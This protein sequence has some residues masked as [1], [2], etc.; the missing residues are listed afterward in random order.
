MNKLAIA[1]VAAAVTAMPVA[2]N[3]EV[4]HSVRRGV[5]QVVNPGFAGTDGWNL[6]QDTFYDAATSRTPD[7]SGS[8]VLTTPHGQPDYSFLET[9]LSSLISVEPGKTYTLSAYV[10]TAGWPNFISPF[11][12]RYG[13]SMPLTAIENTDEVRFGTSQDGVWE[14]IVV[15]YTAEPGDGFAQAKFVKRANTQDFGKVWIDD[16]YFG[17]GIGLERPPSTKTPF[18]GGSVRVDGEGNFEVRRDDGWQPFFPLCVYSDNRRPKSVYSDQGFNCDIRL[19]DVGQ[20][21]AAAAAVSDFNPD[22]LMGGFDFS[23]YLDSNMDVFRDVG[24]LT[25]RLTE[26]MASDAVDNLLLFHWDNENDF[27]R[28]QLIGE[29][30]DRVKAIDMATDGARQRPVYA[31]NGNYGLARSQAAS[32]FVEV[33][34]TY[35]WSSGAEDLSRA[36]GSIG[37]DGLALIQKFEGQTIPV[38]FAQLNEVNGAGAMRRRLYQ[39]IIEGAKGMGFWRDCFNSQCRSEFPPDE[40]RPIDKQEW[41]PDFPGLR[42][43]IDAMLPLIRQPLA[44]D[45]AVDSSDPEV[46]HRV[47]EFE[48]E[49]YLI[50][51]NLSSEQ[52][53]ATFDIAEA[54]YRPAEVVDFFSGTPIIGISDNQFTVAVP[55]VGVGSGTAVLRLRGS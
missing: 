50:L 1:V 34:G 25:D 23:N 20:F 51:A 26:I 15:T 40:A 29:V 13:Q 49:G 21:R 42:R 37:T 48:G 7:G 14:E 18:A 41:W 55:G 30:I 28:W 54:P 33:T 39:A 43:E 27:E 17:E 31:L 19:G 32:E 4:A 44:A 16:I 38:T 52:R 6:V 12:G 36:N 53:I 22:G 47:V 11:V 24:T 5:N 9:A 45:W 46:V 10:K 8:I 2:V 35:F 3:A